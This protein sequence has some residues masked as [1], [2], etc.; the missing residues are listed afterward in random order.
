MSAERLRPQAERA[1]RRTAARGVQRD[2]WIEQEW[3]IVATRIDVALIHIYHVRQCIEIGHCRAVGVVQYLAIRPTIRNAEYLIQR[4]TIGILNYG[5]IELPAHDEIKR[6]AFLE[7]HLRQG[8]YVRSHESDLQPR[9]GRFHGS[10]QL[11]V[12]LK[13]GRAGKQ[14]QEFV[15]P[16]NLDSLLRRHLVRRSVE[17]TGAFQHACRVSQPDRVPIGLDLARGRPARAGA[18]VIILKRRRV[19]QQS[20]QR[21][22]INYHIICAVPAELLTYVSVRYI[23]P[24]AGYILWLAVNG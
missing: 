1:L 12:T 15:I 20:F 17:Q 7:G 4:L 18:A 13:A 22:R 11:D 23:S 2:E 16:S 24:P 3:H 9:V 5:V 14:N 21:H 10:R 8:G 19:Q 6:R